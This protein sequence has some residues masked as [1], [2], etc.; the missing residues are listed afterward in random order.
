MED[1][2]GAKAIKFRTLTSVNTVTNLPEISHINNKAS[3]Y[4]AMKFEND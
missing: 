1:N 3:E 4:I 2:S